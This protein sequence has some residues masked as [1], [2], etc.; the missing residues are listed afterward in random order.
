ML[1]IYWKVIGLSLI[2]FPFC[3]NDLLSKASNLCMNGFQYL[4]TGTMFAH[5]EKK[6]SQ[7][8]FDYLFERTFCRTSKRRILNTADSVKTHANKLHML[9]KNSFE[10]IAARKMLSKVF[11]QNWRAL[12]FY[13]PQKVAFSAF[14]WC[15]IPAW[16]ERRL[17]LLAFFGISRPVW[18][19]FTFDKSKM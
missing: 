3:Y 19:K 2:L 9:H 10:N 18:N 13:F 16:I 1:T 4:G 15:M 14:Y 8:M 12:S 11:L 6:S 5:L 7:K 17:P